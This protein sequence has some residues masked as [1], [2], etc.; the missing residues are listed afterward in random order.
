MVFALDPCQL[1]DGRIQYSCAPAPVELGRLLYA[2]V[3]YPLLPFLPNESPTL[4]APLSPLA[5]GIR[6]RCGCG[7]AVLAL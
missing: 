1:T 7:P 3:V 4:L 5:S 2:R 6:P